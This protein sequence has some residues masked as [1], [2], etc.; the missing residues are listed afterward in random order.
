M[1]VLYA[2]LANLVVGAHLAF[3]AFVMLGGLLVLRWP[4]VTWAHIP[5]AIW[6]AVVELMGWICPLTPLE[7]ELRRRAGEGTYGTSF[8]ENYVVPLLYPGS[9]TREIQLGLG[10]GVVVLNAVV[11]GLVWRKWRAAGS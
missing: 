5:C 7:N 6:G 9:L 2:F 8:L 3:V 1:T 11:Y 10:L 4:R